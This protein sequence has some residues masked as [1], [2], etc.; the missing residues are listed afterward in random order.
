MMRQ[1]LQNLTTGKSLKDLGLEDS[2]FSSQNGCIFRGSRI[3]IPSNLRK[4]ILNELHAG[5]LGMTKMKLLARSYCYWRNLDKDIENMVKNCT[6]CQQKLKAPSKAAIHPWEPAEEPWQRIHIDFA[7]PLRGWWYFIIVDAFSKWVEIIPTKTMTTS[8]CINTLDRLFSTFGFPYVLVSDN[9]PQFTSYDFKEYLKRYKILHR[10]IAPFHPSS[11][12]QAERVVQT[13]KNL[14]QA[15][16]VGQVQEKLN[17]ILKQLRK[18]QH[19]TTGA[20]PYQLMFGR[21]IRTELDLMTDNDQIRVKDITQGQGKF[22]IGQAVLARN[23]NN[24]PKEKWSRGLIEKRIGNVMYII[25]LDDG[26]HWK[27]HVDQIRV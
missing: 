16:D 21:N 8:W 13:A 26:R 7:G 11:N 20:S 27:R 10:T 22:K 4:P 9:G 2:E 23:Y 3:V 6:Q 15:S 5:H 14:I 25:R 1:I 17:I 19:S 18:A 24:N 12:G